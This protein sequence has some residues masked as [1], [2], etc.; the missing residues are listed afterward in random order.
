[1]FRIVF[2]QELYSSTFPTPTFKPEKRVF[3]SFLLSHPTPLY[4]IPGNN[5]LS[6][7]DPRQGYLGLS[8]F[9]CVV[10]KECGKVRT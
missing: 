7:D 10:A 8:L 6:K 1:M 9:F 3:Y 5:R 2:Q 4:F